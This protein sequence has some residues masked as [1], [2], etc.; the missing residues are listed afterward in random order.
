MKKLRIGIVGCGAIGSSLAKAVAKNF[1]QA[2][3]LVALYDINS[4]KAKKL[5]AIISKDKQLAV[6]NLA[7]L[8]IKSELV[9]ESAS[10]KTSWEIARKSLTAGRGIMIMSIGGVVS[11]SGELRALAKKHGVKVYLPSG[12]LSGVDALKSAAL[13]K[14]NQVTLT[15]IK[16]PRAFSGVDYINRKK[17]NLSKIKKDT[18]IF[19]GSAR[20]AMRNFPQNINV[21]GVLSLAG[22]GAGKTLVKIFAS[23]KVKK[24]IHEV[25]ISSA[26]AEIFTRTENILHPDNPKTSYLAV[27]SA[28]ATLKQILEPVKIGT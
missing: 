10:A 5:S 14:I 6:E 27:L 4:E 20:Q 16:H 25:R 17:I 12:A 15:T 1:F 26:A 3:E 24:N 28:I 23:P 19:C 22:I 18:L 11:H 9:I 8:I 21:A 2:A 7:R 13:G